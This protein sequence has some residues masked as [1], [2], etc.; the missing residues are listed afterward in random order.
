MMMAA[1]GIGNA[2]GYLTEFEEGFR[3][4]KRIFKV[5]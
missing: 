4:I 5:R 1:F 3:A 2:L